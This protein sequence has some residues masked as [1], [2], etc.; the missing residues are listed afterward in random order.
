MSIFSRLKNWRHYRVINKDSFYQS[1]EPEHLKR[2]FD[3]YQVDC[4]FDVG[5]NNG[6]YAEM[7]RKKV[8]YKGLIISFE[9]LPDTSQVL[10][11]KAATDALWQIEEVA[12]GAEVGIKEFNVMANSEFSSFRAPRD[13]EESRFKDLNKVTKGVMVKVETLSA[14]LQRLEKKFSFNRPFLKMDTQGFDLEIVK[15]SSDA[16]KRFVGL[17]SELSVR[18]L[19]YDAP[20]YIE[21][22]AEYQK[23][24]FML[25]TFV[26]NNKPHFPYLLEVDCIMVNS[27]KVTR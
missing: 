7:L 10:R 22:L 3:H 14:A 1:L 25:S 24:G 6:Q 18:A 9:P 23:I 20:T 4:V 11:A 15:G 27:L 2:I 8:G 21:S 13:D 26:P 5:A 12:L 19:Y 16:I 17:Q